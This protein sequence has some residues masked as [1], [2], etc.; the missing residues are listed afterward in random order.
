MPQ[1]LH[2]HKMTI[3][4]VSLDNLSQK[5]PVFPILSFGDLFGLLY[6]THLGTSPNLQCCNFLELVSPV[7]WQE[8]VFPLALTT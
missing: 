1:S 8:I 6:M 3:P 4:D 2:R 7:T 5:L